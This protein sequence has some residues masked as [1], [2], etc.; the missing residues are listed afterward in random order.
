LEFE[1]VSSRV[2]GLATDNSLSGTYKLVVEGRRITDTGEIVAVPNPQG[3]IT[4][5][6]D[7]RMLVLIVRNPRPKPSSIEATTDQER[8]ELLR[9]MTA[10]SGTYEFDGKTIKHHI[11]ISW[12]EVWTGTTEVRSVTRDGD[13]LVYTTPPFHFHTDGRLSVNTLIWE[14]VK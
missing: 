12:N 9:T 4:Y 5:S 2:S 10:Y 6:D 11:D 1:T 13:R 8:A 3:Y 14:K 7:G